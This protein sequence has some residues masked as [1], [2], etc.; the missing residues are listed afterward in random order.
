M[1]AVTP[2]EPENVV[3][4]EPVEA[5]P[6]HWFGD[7]ITAAGAGLGRVL[8][9][10]RARS[11]PESISA[12]IG[13]IIRRRDA[14]LVL[15]AIVVG[16]L[17]GM[18][19][20]ILRELAYLIQSVLFGLTGNERLSAVESIAFDY[21][22][23]P[24]VGGLILGLL[25]LLLRRRKARY[26]D[27]VEANALHG[28]KL[29]MIDSLI[30]TGQT[31]ISNGFGASVGLEAA[32]TQM[33]GVAA[34]KI[35]GF[36]HLRRGDLRK[37]VGCGAAGA[38]AAA[39]GAPLTG[40]FY[41]FELIIGT[42]SIATLAPVVAASISAVLVTSLF[43]QGHVIV[44]ISETLSFD[45]PQVLL[46]VASGVAAGGLGILLMRLVGL[47]ERGF[48]RLRMPVWSRP[49]LGGLI[50]GALALASPTVLSA[51]HG[52]LEQA[53]AAPPLPIAIAF[54]LLVLK[55]IA[56]AVSLGSG[57]R[58]GLFF[59]SLFLGALLGQI[60]YWIALA[61]APSL[62]PDPSILMLVG[63]AGLAAAV[64]GGPLTMAFLALEFSGSLPLTIA[65]LVAAVASSML[66]RETFG[67]SFT[68]W[69]FHLRGET[70][71]SAHDVGWMRN[72]TVG[73][74]MRRDVK[75]VPHTMT[76]K[77]FRRS[78]PLGAANRVIATRDDNR[79]A[80]LID[81][82]DAYAPDGLDE[83]GT[84]E[85]I[86]RQREVMLHPALQAVDA[87]AVFEQ[88]NSE[89]IVVV[90]DLNDPVVIGILTEAHL[91]RRYSNE[92]EKARAD[93][94]Q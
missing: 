64:V 41:A 26:V 38:I 74:M 22:F 2:Q 28:G 6:R 79:Y 34:S 61:I 29:S 80:G 57:F 84:V 88:N 27:L 55:I 45:V 62:F 25:G 44:S 9:R 4:V 68:T 67:Y 30:I 63:M 58:G 72:L 90:T 32:Y 31:L 42:Y 1:A 11:W 51:G 87:G 21:A 53:F 94:A 86:L 24:A 10:L 20:L 46:I 48:T 7:R 8:R 5:T 36:L 89:A 78:Y 12:W 69:R 23:V 16:A 50:V 35:G 85:Q 43:G 77:E 91:F 81:V 19:V 93:L 37:L 59:A 82:A 18:C 83:A 15:I 71:R 66:V 65:V 39:F 92:L 70:I 3:K 56:S 52:A 33:G 76:L 14:W 40:A 49:A 47:V 73:K 17:A 60:F 75:I 13:N 54:A